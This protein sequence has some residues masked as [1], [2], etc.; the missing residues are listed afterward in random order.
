[1]IDNDHQSSGVR[2]SGGHV[3]GLELTRTARLSENESH[4]QI[5]LRQHR[6]QT[7]GRLEFIAGETLYTLAKRYDLSP[8]GRATEHQLSQ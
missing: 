1:M 4:G 5:P 7:T 2:P 6:V 3:A 8:A